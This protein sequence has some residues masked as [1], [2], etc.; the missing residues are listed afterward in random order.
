[1]I[2]FRLDQCFYFLD[3]TVEW[4]KFFHFE[5]S[6]CGSPDQCIWWAQSFAHSHIGA[7]A[8]ITS[9][10]ASIKLVGIETCLMKFP[11]R[12]QQDTVLMSEDDFFRAHVC[13]NLGSAEDI[14]LAG[15]VFSL[16]CI[17]F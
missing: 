2:I 13:E 6:D 17:A 11:I 3:R 15:E 16:H 1:M 7:Q 4:A 5:G 9:P 8:G 14:G 12:K 10:T